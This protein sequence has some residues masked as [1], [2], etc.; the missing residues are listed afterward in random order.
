M[1]EGFLPEIDMSD[2]I[3]TEYKDKIVAIYLEKSFS[4]TLLS[5][6]VACK[7]GELR[8]R[9]F[10]DLENIGY[11]KNA[12]WL[13]SLDYILL[14]IRRNSD[15]F[16][17]IKAG[18]SETPLALELF[19]IARPGTEFLN[20]R[21]DSSSNATQLNQLNQL[22]L[23]NADHYTQGRKFDPI[24]VAQDWELS[25]CAGSAIKYISRMGRKPGA[26]KKEDI[27]KAIEFLRRE[28][29]SIS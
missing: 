18:S 1:Y 16:Y 23:P 19:I 5:S 17:L 7:L 20:L 4:H 21:T 15:K 3:V 24:T 12:D 6:R 13:I 8:K 28:L 11:G 27:F 9:I 29:D 25:F 14:Y 2:I 10:E 22:N 26:S